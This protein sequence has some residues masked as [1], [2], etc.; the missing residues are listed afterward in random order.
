MNL[1]HISA[2]DSTVHDA[3]RR[4]RSLGGLICAVLAGLLAPVASAQTTNNFTDGFGATSPDQYI[5]TP[6]GG[7]VDAWTF[8]SGS[9]GVGILDDPQVIN[10]N[11]FGAGGNYLRFGIYGAESALRRK[12]TSGP[13]LDLSLPHFIEFDIRCDAWLPLPT[14]FTSG[15]DNLTLTARSGY[16]TNP[17]GDSTYYIRAQGGNDSSAPNG[18]ASMWGFFHGG[19]FSNANGDGTFTNY[20]PFRIGTNYHFKIEQRTATRTYVTTISAVVDGVSTNLTTQELRW[21]SYATVSAV[22][23]TNSTILHFIGRPSSSSGETNVIAL[24]NLHIY[25]APLDEVAPLI[26]V[27]S[28]VPGTVYF[29][30]SGVVGFTARTLGTTNSIP[31]TS[32]SL[33]LNGVDVSGGLIFGGTANNRTA[34]YTGLVANTIYRAV[35]V[36]SDQAGRSSTNSLLFDT[37]VENDVTTIEAENY[38]FGTNSTCAGNGTAGV[39]DAGGYLQNPLPST[40]NNTSGLYTNQATGYVDRVGWP[41]VDYLDLNATGGSLSS[42]VFRFCDPVGTIATT[43]SEPK[44]P[45]YITENV[46]DYAL[47]H[48]RT[49]EWWNYTHTYPNSNYLVYLRVSSSS[50]QAQQFQLARVTSN[51]SVS[52]Q[53]TVL[54][55]TFNIPY[56]GTVNTYTYVPLTDVL[57]NPV[58]VS[59][60][61]EETVRL[62]ANSILGS[63]YVNFLLFV[64][65]ASTAAPPWL[66]QVAPGANAS[67]AAPQT[68]ITLAIQNG[69]APV[70]TNTII[71]KVNGSNVTSLAT[72]TTTATGAALSYLP[73]TFFGIGSYNTAQVVFGDGTPATLQT[74]QW[75][76]HVGRYLPGTPV[77]VNFQTPT[78]TPTPAGYLADLGAIFGDRGNGYNYGWDLDIAAQARDRGTAG[79]PPD[80]R[81]RTLNQLGTGTPTRF[82]EIE[83]PNGT[84]SAHLVA[85]DGSAV[86]SVYNLAVEGVVVIASNTPTALVHWFE[87]TNDVVVADGRL[88]IAAAG[89]AN[90]KVCYIDIIP[91]GPPLD[92][93]LHNPAVSAGNFSFN[94]ATISRAVHAIEYK[95]NL[96]NSTWS[97]LTNITGTGSA[98]TINDPV[99]PGGQ[100]YYRMR[101]P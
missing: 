85:G 40:Y 29:P 60:N 34:A 17:G 83:L 65:Q 76:F 94:I 96:T 44:R 82:W 95:D 6:G 92:L 24:D 9:S 72:I 45:A 32:I 87:G 19:E 78:F 84:Y 25:Q 47:Q 93:T 20:F 88:T 46:P 18:R 73:P 36:V 2:L 10:T 23:Q 35:I 89:G 56:T 26:T 71:L 58:Q 81:Y 22:N 49:G 43:P 7:W 61:G 3:R 91:A 33:T 11:P 97:P 55:G 27:T 30:A 101:I 90:N 42:N 21:R 68:T 41:G 69:S 52:N 13:D 79:T 4:C 38:N 54:L 100:R 62:T 53:T 70:D 63:A 15:N 50:V 37:L 51:R 75:N 48:I 67:N 80:D 99:P 8:G 74:N 64:P 14:T 66:S 39:V 98:I 86:D 31:T 57:G 16:G 12:Y 77:R 59:L 28:P 1:N 5:G